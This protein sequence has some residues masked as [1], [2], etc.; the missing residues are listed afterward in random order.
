MFAVVLRKAETTFSYLQTQFHSLTAKPQ[1]TSKCY[2]CVDT[3]KP[4]TDSTVEIKGA[5]KQAEETSGATRQ[6]ALG[7]SYPIFSDSKRNAVRTF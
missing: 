4:S 2:S 6:A 7:S 1:S 3:T 5:I